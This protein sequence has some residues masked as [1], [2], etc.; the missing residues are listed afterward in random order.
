MGKCKMVNVALI[1]FI[2]CLDISFVLGQVYIFKQGGKLNT[3]N[4]CRSVH[5]R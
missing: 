2:F 3:S 5:I 4:Y 1:L